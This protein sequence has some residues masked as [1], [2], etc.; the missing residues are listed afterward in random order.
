[1]NNYEKNFF[2]NAYP[3]FRGIFLTIMLVSLIGNIAAYY[4]GMANGINL[5]SL[6]FLAFILIVSAVVLRLLYLVIIK[7]IK[8]VNV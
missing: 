5:V 2:G 4:L 1:M 6:G 8:H 7:I 3:W